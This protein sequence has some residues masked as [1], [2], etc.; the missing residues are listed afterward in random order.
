MGSEGGKG[1]GTCCSLPEIDNKY[2]I[3]RYIIRLII[4]GSRSH[5][6]DKIKW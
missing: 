5:T 4:T 2:N 3:L 1:E 6:K